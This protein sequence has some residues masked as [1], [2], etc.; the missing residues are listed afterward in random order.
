MQS[1]ERGIVNL[2]Q[3]SYSGALVLFLTPI[4]ADGARLP[5]SVVKIDKMKEIEEEVRVDVELSRSWYSA[6]KWDR[7]PIPL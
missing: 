6:E 2:I 3:E 4:R 5:T 7:M 1:A